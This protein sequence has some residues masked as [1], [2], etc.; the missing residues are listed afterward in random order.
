MMPAGLFTF[1]STSIKFIADSSYGN[2]K[3]QLE[4][5]MHNIE[6]D[7]EGNSPQAPLDRL[8]LQVLEAAYPTISSY[9]LRRLTIVLESTVLLKGSLSTCDLEGLLN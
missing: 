2:P 6:M 3:G 8:Y 1:A 4:R 7:S 5:L 9:L